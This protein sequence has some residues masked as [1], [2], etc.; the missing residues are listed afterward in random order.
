MEKLASGADVFH[1]TSEGWGTLPMGAA[2]SAVSDTVAFNI[3]DFG[4][5]DSLLI[6]LLAQ[7]TGGGA[8]A[9]F[10]MTASEV[11]EP[12]TMALLSLG[13]LLLR[14]RK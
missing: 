2:S 1:L 7:G 8:F 13:G 6:D 5:G 10:E 9:T 14:R 12:A 4:I 11:P 3:A